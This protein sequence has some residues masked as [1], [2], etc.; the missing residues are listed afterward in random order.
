LYLLGR[1]GMGEAIFN[2]KVD[3][4]FISRLIAFRKLAANAL[5]A[6]T[7]ESGVVKIK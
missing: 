7:S 4:V 5:K 3:S 1:E 6:T 2:K